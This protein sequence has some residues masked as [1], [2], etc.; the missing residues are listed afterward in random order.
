[1]LGGKLG[2]RPML[3][4]CWYREILNN[5]IPQ[6]ICLRS[7]LHRSTFV[8]PGAVCTSEIEQVPS[9]PSPTRPARSQC[10][11][12]NASVSRAGLQILDT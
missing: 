10:T 5:S 12:S 6:V 1:M 8:R 2:G 9:L 7:K 11:Y 3:T 4:R